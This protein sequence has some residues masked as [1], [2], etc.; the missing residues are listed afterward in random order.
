LERAHFG[1]A[2][3]ETCGLFILNGTNF[4]RALRVIAS[5]GEGWDHVS[6]SLPERCPTWAE[7]EQVKRLFFRD[8]ETAMQL[9]VPPTDHISI[10]PFCLHL[11]RPHGA[12]IPRPPGWMVGP[13]EAA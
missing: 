7:M 5:S 12:E 9:H 3:D 13:S 11:W 1:C 4:K 2:G 6:V 10:H 8:D